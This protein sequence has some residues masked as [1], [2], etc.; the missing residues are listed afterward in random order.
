MEEIKNKESVRAELI[1]KKGE[2]SRIFNLE[3]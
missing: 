2:D 1:K 3:L